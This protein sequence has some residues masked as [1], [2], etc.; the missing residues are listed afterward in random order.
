MSL[1]QFMNEAI[2]PWLK[3]EGPDSDIV[4]SSRIR[5]AR[6]FEEVPFPIIAPNEE[7]D[8]IL[9]FFQDEYQHESFK[10]YQEL[11]IVKMSQLKPIEKQVLVEK[12]LISP[13]LAEKSD[14]AGALISKSEQVSVM[15][16]E[17]DHIRI[18]LYF[19]GFQLNKAIE[20]AF[21]FDDWLEEKINYAFDENRG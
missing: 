9:T 16:N 19:P 5:L 7:L 14:T 4:L 2:S 20:E 11:E 15:V 18:Q 3:E 21:A 1:Q 13:H 8:D 12:H 10:N 6:N 17:E